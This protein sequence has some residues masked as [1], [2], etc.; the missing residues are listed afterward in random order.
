MVEEKSTRVVVGSTTFE[1]DH[2]DGDGKRR[3]QEEIDAII[4]DLLKSAD[5]EKK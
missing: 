2:I 5:A 4:A 1:V 3:T